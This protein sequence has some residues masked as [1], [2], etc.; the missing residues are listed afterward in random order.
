MAGNEEHGLA[1]GRCHRMGSRGIST[2]LAALLALAGVNYLSKGAETRTVPGNSPG[3]TATWVAD[4][5]TEHT[6]KVYV[7]NRWL[8]QH[9]DA[10]DWRFVNT[11]GFS[12]IEALLP[13]Q[14]DFFEGIPMEYNWINPPGDQLGRLVS[15]RSTGPINNYGNLASYRFRVPVGTAPGTYNFDLS[16]TFLWDDRFP[17]MQEQPHTIVNDSFYV[18]APKRGDMNC[19]GYVDFDD[20][21]PFVSAL[22]GRAGYEAQLPNCSWLNGDIDL[23]GAVDF[24]DINPFVS[25]LVAGGCE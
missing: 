4:G 15:E 16:D 17:T 3:A 23:N 18:I 10:V 24:D 7:D 9:T 13:T 25:C 14:N 22:V 11:P 5:R 21:N 2:G 6:V 20:I 8:Y 1:T 12:F 19:D